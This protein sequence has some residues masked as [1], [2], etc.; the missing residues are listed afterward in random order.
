MY[1]D[2]YLDY[3]LDKPFTYSIPEGMDVVPGMR[4]RVNFKGRNISG[5]TAKVHENKPSDF[6]VKDIL[7]VID[8]E[9]VFGEK[10]LD[11]ARY[12]ASEYLSSVGEA[13]STAIP[14]SG[15]SANRQKDRFTVETPQIISL[16][17]DQKKIS[18][19]MI[20]S[21][22]EGNLQHLIFGVTGSGKTEIY[23]ETALEIMKRGKSVIYLVPE[24][25]LSS[26]IYKRLF[27]VFGRE[28]ILYHSGI[29]ANQKLAVWKKFY[30]G[31]VK[32]AVGARSAVF[33]QCPDLGLIIV[34][35]EH[36]GSYK[37]NSTPRYNA[38]RIAFYRSRKENSLLIMG[39]ATPS[40]ESLYAA[41]KGIMQLHK[42]EKRF[43][44]AA[45]PKIE[46][47]KT[48]G[49][50]KGLLSSVLKLHIKRAV[51]SGKQAIL[52]LNRRGFS[53]LVVCADCGTTVECPSCS[54]SMN[55]H[56]EG[57]LLCHYCGFTKP[58]PELCGKCGSA[59]LEKLGSG[60][61]KIEDEISEEFKNYRIFRL[62]HDT[63][64]K[65]DAS[66]NLIDD[67]SKGNIDI[68]LGTQMVAKG[69]DFANVTVAG[70]LLA[71]IGLH[72][73]DFRATERIFSLLMQVSGRSGRGNFPGK[74]IIQ[75]Y[76]PENPVYK[77]LI[78]QDYIGFYKNESRARKAMNYPPFSRLARLLIRGEDESE[79]LKAAE[80]L[81]SALGESIEKNKL[82]IIL[83]GPS[84]APIIKIAKNFRHHI[85]L[86]CKSI[87]DLR[88]VILESRSSVSGKGLY[89]EIDIDPYEML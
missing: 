89:L 76:D 24:I 38:R 39:S 56:R 57:N 41:E 16:T 31:E 15:K 29:T 14:S 36:D 87:D 10:L 25:S 43:G 20:K 58:F 17:E 53:P 32:I 81:K 54:I 12:T 5:F 64:R 61:Q 68:L 1:A 28:M 86:K 72:I 52:L 63:S 67:M 19:D 78:E 88:K 47:V 85:I 27:K 4:V 37:E 62:D 6:E 48:N 65:K 22:D 7:A 49:R 46:I 71:D 9:P 69:F 50:E 75:T 80:K 73:P 45:L 83:L 23:I 77:Y 44:S 34:D 42:I 35:E 84:S 60:T 79:V 13:I 51:D 2:I 55:F 66:F 18:D 40:I 74:V 30:S 8:N 70:V 26:Q 3:P 59:E 82:N 11:L 21:Y 33:L